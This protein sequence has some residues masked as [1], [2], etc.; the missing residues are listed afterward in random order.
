MRYD[1]IRGGG[2]RQEMGLMT[3]LLQSINVRGLIGSNDGDGHSYGCGGEIGGEI[4]GGMGCV[5][6]CGE[7]MKEVC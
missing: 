6:R 2:V 4:G 5:S 7:G 1:R 3:T